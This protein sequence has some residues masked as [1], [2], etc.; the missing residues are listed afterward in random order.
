MAW[1]PAASRPC[2]PRPRPTIA[3]RPWGA[4]ASR[5]K[6]PRR[7]AFSPDRA[8]ATSPARPCT[9]AAAPPPERRDRLVERDVAFLR[10]LL[11]A[12]DLVLHVL[13]DLLGAHRHRVDRFGGE[14]LAQRGLRERLVDLGVQ[15]R[16]DFGGQFRRPYDPVPLQRVESLVAELLEGRQVRLQRMALEPGDGERPDLAR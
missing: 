12:R 11:V 4:A 13:A 8:R 7:C 1:F 16:G 15:P 14:P 5:K 2:A 6:S 3:N 10:E 9:S